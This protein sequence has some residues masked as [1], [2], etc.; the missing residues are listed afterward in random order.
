MGPGACM[1]KRYT[2]VLSMI[3]K[4]HGTPACPRADF[5]VN[6][7]RAQ[8]TRD[9]ESLRNGESAHG[10]MQHC[11]F[12]LWMLLACTGP[13]AHLCIAF[14]DGD[15]ATTVFDSLLFPLRQAPPQRNQLTT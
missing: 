3:S 14:L 7:A 5:L 4:R 6:Q 13:Y 9:F 11:L 1:V 8:A 2:C 10:V 12:S 15:T